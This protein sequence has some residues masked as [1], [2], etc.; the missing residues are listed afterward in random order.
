MGVIKIFLYLST[1]CVWW[2]NP[3]LAE[4]KLSL[5]V[6]R[7]HARSVARVTPTLDSDTHVSEWERKLSSRGGQIDNNLSN[8]IAGS[9]AFAVLEKIVA[10]G[11]TKAG[12]K[13]P[14]MLAGCIILFAFLFLSDLFNPRMAAVVME[15]LTPAAA[16]LAKWMPPFFIPGLVVLPLSPSVGGTAEVS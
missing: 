12:I 5:P 1:C 14:P 16:F 8:A 3:A 2:H 7:V 13:Y 4:H 11:M 10:K 15:A 9:I 6:R